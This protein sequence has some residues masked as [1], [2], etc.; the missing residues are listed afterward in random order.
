[1][2]DK[3]IVI[4]G[5][6][7]AGLSAGC[8]G[9]M[10]G[11]KT[12]IF[13][14]HN[15]PGGLCTSWKR[16]GYTFDGCIHWLVGSAPGNDFYRIWQ[17]LGAIQDRKIVNHEE[18][19]RFKGI[20]DKT[21]ILYTNVDKLEQHLK[22]LAPEDENLIKEFTDAIR[23]FSD[24]DMKLSKPREL[25]SAFDR[26]KMYYGIRRYL[27]HFAKWRNLSIQEY[28]K[29]FKNPFMRKVF[30]AAFNL[31]DFPMLGVIFTL[32]WMNKQNAGYPIG[33][34]LAFAQ[35]IESRYLA[36]G[37]EIN[38]NS[39]VDKILVENNR[40]VG[41]R[42]ADGTEH[43]ADIV[44]SA[45]DGHATIFQMLDGKYIDNKIKG[46]YESLPIFQPIIQVSLGV[47]LNLSNQP[48][49]ASYELKEPIVIAGEMRNWFDVKHYC[50]DYSLAPSGK[51]V[52]ITILFSNYDYWKDIF[53]D[54]IRYGNE[55]QQ[56]GV[57]VIN[58]LEKLYP[59]ISEKI[60]VIDIATPMTYE[61]YTG[62]WQGS[63]EGWLITTK[64]LNMHISKT[65]PGLKNFYMAGQWVEP[66]G[67]VPT[68]AMSGRNVIQIICA[69]DKKQFITNAP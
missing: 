15:L 20:E 6:G 46:Y 17:E 48:H 65:L 11:Y 56:I 38:Y 28:A 55:K 68:A 41:I 61:R 34:S 54:R 32:A 37:G 10:N 50:Y 23:I 3:S 69:S 67:G 4:I 62:N 47:N 39:R 14:L 8:Y 30:P 66:G 31:P 22:E 49:Y 7:I 35:A 36:L 29:R 5:A 18:F 12:R 2:A 24:F 25:S 58:Q 57:A 21:Y 40:S 44:I 60:E 19:T 27:K 64:T 42:L 13:E 63:M 59:G 9:Q 51:S 33:G 26:I 45:A 16:K 53:K 52:L 43:K 1:M